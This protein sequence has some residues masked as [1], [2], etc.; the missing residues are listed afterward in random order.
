MDLSPGTLDTLFQALADPTRRT[1][2]ERLAKGPASV[3]DLAA[4]LEMTLPAALDHVRRLEA[5]GLVA[6]EKQG[7]V[8]IA[9]LVAAR[10]APVTTWLDAQR[11]MWEARLD[12]FERFAVRQR[13]ANTE[14]KDTRDD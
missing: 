14:S 7:R 10:Y 1:M 3:S 11:A 12:R 6:T 5:A 4:P 13:D 8:R 9:R 2:L